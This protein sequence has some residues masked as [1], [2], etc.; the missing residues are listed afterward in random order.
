MTVVNIFLSTL[1]GG[2]IKGHTKPPA[3]DPHRAGK[4]LMP[5]DFLSE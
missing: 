4:D 5:F 3:C 2:E 1:C